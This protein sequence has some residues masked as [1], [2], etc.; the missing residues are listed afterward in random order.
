MAGDAPAFG[1]IPV[2]PA[3]KVVIVR[4]LWHGELTEAMAKSAAETLSTAGIKDVREVTVTGSFELPLFAKI[5]LEEWKCDGVIALGVVLRGETKHADLIASEAA[6]ACMDLQMQT[7]KPVA[8]EVLLV[9]SLEVAKKRA[10]GPDSKGTLAAKTLLSSLAG[11]AEM[12]R[13]NIE[14]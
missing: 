7:K 4:S 10:V 5:A 9:D 14:H 1:K 11:K 12:L 2:D 13:K 6:R 8:F 3:W